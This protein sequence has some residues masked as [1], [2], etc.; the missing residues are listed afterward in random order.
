MNPRGCSTRLF[1]KD[2]RREVETG[3]APSPFAAGRRG[4][5]RLYRK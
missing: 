2:K 3:L 5:P 4:E 1:G